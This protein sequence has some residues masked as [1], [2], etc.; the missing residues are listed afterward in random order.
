M[1]PSL[2]V[3]LFRPLKTEATAGSAGAPPTEGNMDTVV[4]FVLVVISLLAAFFAWR[5]SRKNS[6]LS[7]ELAQTRA[8]IEER[9]RAHERFAD[10]FTAVT[11]I[12]AEAAVVKETLHAENQVLQEEL[13]TAKAAH[14]AFLK[15]SQQERGTL[16]VQYETANRTYEGLKSE[17]ALLEENLEDISFG[18]Y[19]PHFEFDTAED[20]KR[21]LKATRDRQRELVRSGLAASSPTKWTV[22]NSRTEGKK[23]ERQYTKL[24]L[25]AFN[26]ECDAAVANVS[27]NNA[28]KMEQRVENA[29]EAISKLGDVMNMSINPTY[30]QKKLNEVSLTHEYREKRHQEREEQRELA[31]QMREEEKAER[32]LER[33]RADAEREELRN[34][35]AL[36][37]AREE[38]AKATG[39]QLEKLTEQI[40]SLERR[41]SESHDKKEKAVARAQ[42]TKSWFVYVISNVGAF[43]EGVVKIGM[44]RRMEPMDRVKE[45][46][47]ASVP[48]PFDLHVMMFSNNAPDLEQSLHAH[49]E[50]RRVNLVN[51]RKEFYRDVDLDEVE[52]FI[53]ARGVTA[54][55]VK[56]AEARE[57]GFPL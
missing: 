3:I 27:W 49:F 41:V 18:L 25:R 40:A 8:D 11:D 54:Q 31:R 51:R 14:S 53:K 17:V 28:T 9:E 7:A 19:K 32:E 44:T 35:E 6:S 22:G 12:E 29:F 55:F 5:A 47:D 48:F 45:L 30:L 33:A 36:E 24:L 46:G 56:L 10:R 38:A 26:G 42:L 52:E 2:R 39:H 16:E 20:Y 4:L 1:T 34:Q 57:P 23:I 50:G 43:D 37:K 15:H 21:E 13:A